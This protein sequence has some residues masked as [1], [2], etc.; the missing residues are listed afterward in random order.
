MNPAGREIPP[1]VRVFTAG[2]VYTLAMMGVI[3]FVF[4]QKV[5]SLLATSGVLAM[6]FGLALQMNLSN[7]FSG[8]AINMER[9]FRMG[10]WIRVADYEP[11]KVVSITWRTTRIETLDQNIICIPNSVASDSTVENLSYPRE[12]YRSEQM[13]HVDPGAKP[14]WVEKIL[15]DAVIS[16]TGIMRD[17]APS[18]VFQGVK[19]WSACYAVRFFCEDYEQSI[20]VA[21]E[22]WRDIVRILRFAGFESVIHQ[23]FT[24]FHLRDKGAERPDTAALLID[25][26]D[27]FQPFDSNKKAS[28]CES[29]NR[30]QLEPE[31]TVVTQGDAGESLFIVAEGALMVQMTMED[32]TVLEVGRLGPGDF[33]GEMALLT[34]EP[35]GATI[36]TLTTSQ[37]FEIEKRDI[38]PII[39]EF[40]EIAE[41]LSRILTRRMLENLRQRNDHYA[42][43]DEEKSLARNILNKI[44]RFFQLTMDDR[45]PKAAVSN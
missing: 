42:S 26:V 13:V 3:A 34:G 22:V 24:L 11:G 8:I 40:P 16:A 14:E 18:V 5:T 28:L 45:K 30:I 38:E 20:P 36:T 39:Q 31:R 41:D 9:P 7:V 32:S 15:Y 23:E 19:D 12:A 10:D 1:V 37:I 4:D 17:P 44:G 27:V 33:F 2:L 43:L 6:I 25:D 29:M 35:R 21:G